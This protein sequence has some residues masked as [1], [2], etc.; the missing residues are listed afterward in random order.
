MSRVLLVCGD[1][2]VRVTARTGAAAHLRGIRD[3]LTGLGHDVVVAC[4]APHP[5]ETGGPPEVGLPFGKIAGLGRRE[6]AE[7]QLGRDLCARAQGPWDLVWERHGL[8][9]DGPRRLAAAQ[10]A[11]RL[12]EVNAPLRLE[13]DRVSQDALAKDLEARSLREAW[14]VVVVS[15]WLRTWAEEVVGVDPAK[16]RLVPNGTA[17]GPIP[18]R[19]PRGEGLVMGFVGSLQPW[20]GLDGLVAVLERLPEARLVVVGEGPAPPPPHPRLTLTGDLP[21]E[22]LPAMISTFDVAMLPVDPARPWRCPLK[23]WDYRA[24]GVPIVAGWLPGMADW[25]GPSDEIVSERAPEAWA[26]AV[27]RAAT[28]P[29]RP[30]LRPWSRVVQE[31]L[32]QGPP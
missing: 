11:R 12:V 20:Q 32:V 9:Q 6:A 29:R 25:I 18:E 5:G 10:G 2:G 21:A 24:A 26:A 28:R 23:L 16:I 7:R 14:R 30:F 22:A 3:G 19:P 8:F 27:R 15:P 4:A 1:P 17:G 31:A 13:R